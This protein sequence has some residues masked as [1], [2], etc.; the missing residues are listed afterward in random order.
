M[1]ISLA[2][3]IATESPLRRVV[4]KGGYARTRTRTWTRT[5]TILKYTFAFIQQF[6]PTAINNVVFASKPGRRSYS[7]FNPFI[8]ACAVERQYATWHP[9]PSSVVQVL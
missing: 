9:M 6:I 1:R 8:S 5:H 3:K 2:T 7:S 4:G